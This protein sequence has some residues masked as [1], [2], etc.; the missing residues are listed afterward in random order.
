V[1]PII[2][3]GP[4]SKATLLYFNQS[5]GG[6][7]ITQTGGASKE[8]FFVDKKKIVNIN[9]FIEEVKKRMINM[10]KDEIKII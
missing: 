2:F 4:D 6:L 9:N 7:E 1:Y 8:R 5:I 10:N 3:E